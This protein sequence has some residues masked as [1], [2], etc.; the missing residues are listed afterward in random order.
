MGTRT[1]KS[2]R[3]STVALAFYFV[4]L[5][6]QFFSRKIF[7][8]HLGTEVLGL[9][10]TATNLLQFL[11]LAELG[12][13]AAIGYS[14]YKPL[15]CDDHRQVNDIVSIQGYLYRKIGLAVLAGGCVLMCFFPWFFGK[16]GV[17]AW[18]TYATFS[19]LLV[20]A[21]A[22]YFFNYRQIVLTSDQKD[23]KLVSVTQTVRTIKVLLQILAIKFLP[24]GYVWWLA[25]ELAATLVI[26]FGIN[27]ILRREYPWLKTDYRQGKQLMR[28]YPH[29]A[30]KTKQLFFHKM[31]GFAL[32]QTSP[33]IIYAYASLTL[34]ALYGNYMLIVLGVTA[35][36]NAIFNSINAGVGNLVAEGDRKR[37][38]RVFEELFS[39][40]F[41]LVGT[42]CYGVYLLTPPF[43]TLW[44]GP[45]YLLD[46]LTLILIVAILY[47]SVMRSVVDAYI[48]AYGMYHDVWAP[49]TEA[50][51][52]VGL[53]VLFG[54][55]WGLHGILSGVLVSLL[56][57]VF[58]WKPYFLFREGLREPLSK[59]VKIYAKH[60]AALAIVFLACRFAASHTVADPTAS[61]FGFGL[62][63]ATS[64]GLFFVL[65]AALLYG[66][67]HGMR[68]FMSRILSLL[69][70][71]P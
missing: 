56:L 70:R 18:Y 57:I 6:L 20:S 24:D 21:L 68:D 23:Y 7:L 12:I 49:I 11:N 14:L 16:A 25:L 15:A 45:E 51:V 22:G 3:N 35:L 17:P 63:A 58:L 71:Q 60:L 10:T 30:T 38:I 1:T 8:D 69:K 43:I 61:Y 36:L 13:G 62:Y 4:S 26:V 29:I 37:I 33:L 42:I 54:Y 47:L 9:N 39:S 55:F 44:I 40:R 50:A 67:S 66:I 32:T 48:A 59:Y 52:N 53:S 46:N 19:V 41:L 2:V 65:L 34:V 5:V 64:L 28:E 31:A 27:A